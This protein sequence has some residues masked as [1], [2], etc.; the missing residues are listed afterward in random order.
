M[1]LYYREYGSYSEERPSIVM[2]H[3]LFGSSVNWH[4]IA[5]G[6]SDDYHV[7][8]PD[9]RNHGRSPHSDKM[10]Y[11]VMVDDLEYLLE[12][13]GLDSVL[14]IG[15]SM[16]GK[17]AMLFA[18]NHPHRVTGLVVVDIAPVSYLHRFDTIFEALREVNLDRLSRRSEA[19]DVL[20]ALLEPHG[21]RQYLLQS[22]FRDDGRWQWRMNLDALCHAIDDITAFPVSSA[23]TAYPGST[24]FVYGSESDYLTKQHYKRIMMLFPHA[25]LRTI[26]GAG[27]WVYSEQPEAFASALWGFLGGSS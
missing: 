22:L 23:L 14:L 2:L 21:L 3:G 24:L 9:L 19:D 8:V 27:H 11:P 6:L 16:G 10:N 25:R 7:I 13:H 17:V 20:A 18:L 15:H 4:S 1:N 12:E 26:S 5:R